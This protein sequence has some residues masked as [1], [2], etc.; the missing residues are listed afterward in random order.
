MSVTLNSNVA[1]LFVASTDEFIFSKNGCTTSTTVPVP[2][3]PGKSIPEVTVVAT[4][5]FPE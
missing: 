2:L 1:V 5:L 4:F 3:P